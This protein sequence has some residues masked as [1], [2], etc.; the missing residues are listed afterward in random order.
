MHAHTAPPLPSPR[1]SLPTR[2]AHL[3]R[4]PTHLC[5]VGGQVLVLKSV[6]AEPGVRILPALLIS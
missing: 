5:R 1:F 4:P 6:W 3:R 2:T